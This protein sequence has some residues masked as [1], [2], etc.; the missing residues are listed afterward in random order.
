MKKGLTG[1][2]LNLIII[3]LSASMLML[4]FLHAARPITNSIASKQSFDN[5]WIT[6]GYD[7]TALTVFD[8]S[9]C[10]PNSIVYKQSQSQPKAVYNDTELKKTVYSV[11][12]NVITDVFGAESIANRMDGDVNSYY[13]HVANSDSF[14]FFNY[15]SELPYP[16]IYAFSTG[17]NAVNYESCSR[18]ESFY[19]SDVALIL[20]EVDNKLQYRCFTFDRS[21]NAYEFTRS[22]GDKYV[23]PDA[24]RAHLEAYSEK[25]DTVDFA[26]NFNKFTAQQTTLFP[27]E[28]MINGFD[29][30][31]LYANFAISDLELDDETEIKELLEIFDINIEKINKYNEDD[32]TTVFIGTDDRLEVTSDGKLL[33]TN[34]NSPIELKEII[35]FSTSKSNG[36]TAFDMLK[37]IIVINA[38]LKELYPGYVGGSAIPKISSVYKDSDGRSVFEF[39]YYLNGVKIGLEP[40]IKFIFTTKGLTEL[41]VDLTSFEQTPVRSAT[42]PKST[43]YNRLS[44]LSNITNISSLTPIY[45]N[46]DGTYT[47]N[48]F[49]NN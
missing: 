38:K 14:I 18:S 19:I 30:S 48:W 43:V 41:T 1:V 7:D 36:Y 6:Q 40:S 35:G 28:I 2:L 46:N 44:E 25:F 21:G 45:T 3:I 17:V 11:L 49:T 10:L 24:D 32:G 31:E 29:Y 47:I 20:E 4:V 26:V 27:L 34:T 13:N 23:L 16:C 5:L 33:F 42:V 8:S 12:S 37:S 9:M 15:T 22:D 39:S